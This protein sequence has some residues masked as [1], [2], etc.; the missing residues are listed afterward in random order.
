MGITIFLLLI[1]LPISAFAES[2]Y[3]AWLRYTPIADNI[4]TQYQNLPKIVVTLNPKQVIESAEEELSRGISGLFGIKLIQTKTF[5][6]ESAFILGTIDSIKPLISEKDLPKGLINDGFYVR[7]L[8]ISGKSCILVTALNENGVLYGTFELLKKFASHQKIDNLNET[9]NPYSTIRYT[10]EW[11]NLDGSIERG[12]G[13]KSIFYANNNVVS[14]LSRANDYARLL[15]SIGINGCAVNNVN[16]NTR[17]IKP[18]FLPELKRLGDV[19]RRWGI[20]IVISV[21]FASPKLVGGLETYD[22]L[23]SH[24]IEFW[25]NKTQ[26]IYSYV[27]DLAGY[28]LKADAEGRPGM[29]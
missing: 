24:V 12:F 23:D 22:P 21:D 7:T 6:N 2:G 17:V 3:D 26:E 5:S 19:F 10:N 18:E 28:V 14:N 11:N 20:R 9:Q 27:P 4:R 29:G 1:V 16:A 15:A 13:G 8:D 25:N